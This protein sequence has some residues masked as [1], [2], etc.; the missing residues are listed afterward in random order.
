MTVERR[1]PK[2]QRELEETRITEIRAD[3]FKVRC[4][5][6]NFTS[7]LSIGELEKSTVT[8]TLPDGR[9]V[10]AAS[11]EVEAVCSYTSVSAIEDFFLDNN[12][13]LDITNGR[14]MSIQVANADVC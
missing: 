13:V 7:K 4:N 8:L 2:C 12:F 14:V 3:L 1:C 5:G 6:C 11:K 9:T 10:I